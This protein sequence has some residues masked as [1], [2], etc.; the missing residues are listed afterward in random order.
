MKKIL[1]TGFGALLLSGALSSAMADDAKKPIF[2]GK[3]P[4]SFEKIDLD[5]DGQISP[6]EFEAHRKEMHE[7]MMQQFKN[8]PD[9]A[10]SPHRAQKSEHKRTE[11]GTPPWLKDGEKP[12]HK[13]KHRH[14]G[15][16]QKKNKTVKPAE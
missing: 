12:E 2:D 9:H 3:K 16:D 6:A 8:R 1:L 7:K 4:A 14:K 15:D 11:G 5:G 13:I 10:K